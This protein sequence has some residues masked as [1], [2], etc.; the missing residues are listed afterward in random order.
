MAFELSH[1]FAPSSFQGAG[2]GMTHPDNPSP[3]LSTTLLSK[4]ENEQHGVAQGHLMNFA[5]QL[6]I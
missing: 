1:S 3:V 2:E 5:N 4:A 6:W